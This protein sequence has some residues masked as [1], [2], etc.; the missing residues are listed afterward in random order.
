[1]TPQRDLFE[2]VIRRFDQTRRS[3]VSNWER[4]RHPTGEK[5]L[6]EGGSTILA[7][8]QWAEQQLVPILHELW[9]D[10]PFLCEEAGTSELD[11]IVPGIS[12]LPW[13]DK[14]A[15]L[16]KNLV[17]VDG[18]DGSALYFNGYFEL[19]TMMTARIKD[20]RAVAGM[21]MALDSGYMYHTGVSGKEGVFRTCVDDHGVVLKD[22]PWSQWSI[23]KGPLDTGI[24]ITDDNK[25][26]D[27]D[28]Q[29]LVINKLTGKGAGTRYPTNKPSGAGPIDVV[30]GRAVAYVSSNG[31]H[32]DDGAPE[33]LA[34]ALG[35]V[36]K[37]LDGSPVPFN[38]VRMPPTVFAR[39]V[40]TF[41]FV[42][43][44]AQG[45]LD[46]QAEENSAAA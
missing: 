2:K 31:R 18:V 35:M 14:V 32:W 12:L 4:M 41:D 33:A 26:V 37:C 44:K 13:G 29:R 24:I 7:A 27:E 23:P 19:T 6:L 25:S 5:Q 8:D 38:R 36:Y 46:L 42:Q 17:T 3:L 22:E 10:E 43:Q 11:K 30:M 40:E 28:F 20:G 45:W 34:S 1:M 15:D 16:P 21:I 39:D 9:P